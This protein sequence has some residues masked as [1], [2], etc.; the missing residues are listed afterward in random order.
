[1]SEGQDESQKTEQPTGK[2]LDE[3]HGQ[4]QFAI[5]REIH[6]WMMIAVTLLMLIWWVPGALRRLQGSFAAY[7]A[8][9]WQLPADPTALGLILIRVAQDYALTVAVPVLTF[10]IAGVASSILQTGW[11]V[12]FDTIMPDLGK[13]SPLAGLKRLLSMGNQAVELLKGLLKIGVVGVVAYLALQPMMLNIEHYAGMEMAQVVSEIDRLAFRLLAG[14]LTVMTI[15]AGADFVY[16]NYQFIQKLRMT[17]Q[18]V[19]DEYKQTE[20]DPVIK[21]RLRQLRMERARQRMMSNVPR[22]DVVV[23][24]PTHFAVALKYDPTT[25][26]APVVLA[27]GVDQIALNIRKVAEENDVAVITNPPLARALYAVVEIDQ[28]VPPEHYRAVAELITYV[29]KLKGKSL[30][31]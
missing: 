26:G 2:R 28:E 8:D 14:V 4:G 6:H 22:A 7:I 1:M 12:T 31:D 21:G 17:K 10:M 9:S 20:G 27:K 16:Q 24:N 11:H 25:M 30:R 18:E 29:F 15:L 19:K 5:S 13:I 3:A 23:T